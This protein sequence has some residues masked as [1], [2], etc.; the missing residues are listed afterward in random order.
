M[1]SLFENVT[2]GNR[3]IKFVFCK[4]NELRGARDGVFKFM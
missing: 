1:D 3:Y 2:L 4:R